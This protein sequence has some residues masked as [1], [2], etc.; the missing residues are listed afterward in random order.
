MHRLSQRGLAP[1]VRQRHP[2]NFP[3]VHR[4]RTAEYGIP[5]HHVKFHLLSDSIHPSQQSLLVVLWSGLLARPPTPLQLTLSASRGWR[6]GPA[7][8]R[9]TYC[10][11]LLADTRPCIGTL[12]YAGERAGIGPPVLGLVRPDIRAAAFA[13]GFLSFPI[14]I[15]GL[16]GWISVPRRYILAVTGSSRCSLLPPVSSKLLQPP[17]SSLPYTVPVSGQAGAVLRVIVHGGVTGDRS[18][19]QMS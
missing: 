8:G 4:E 6:P 12:N 13:S 9:S 10:S 14:P 18:P 3:T 7:V 11:N 19:L 15:G 17:P 5:S 2:S 1:E 16:A